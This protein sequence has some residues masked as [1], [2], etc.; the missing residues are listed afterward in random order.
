MKERRLSAHGM[1]RGRTRSDWFI[2][3]SC[4]ILIAICLTLVARGQ[5][6]LADDQKL[7]G[8]Q[9]NARGDDPR[10]RPDSFWYESVRNAPVHP[11][12]DKLVAEFLEQKKAGKK[13]I[14]GINTM[15]YSSPVYVAGENTP[16]IKVGVDRCLPFP[17]E[18]YK[19]IA[20][21][22]GAVPIPKGATPAD[23]DDSEMTVYQPSTDTLWEFWQMR[24][25]AS[26]PWQACWGGRLTGVSQSIGIFP[27]PFGASATGLPFVGG[28]LT[29]EELRDPG[30]KGAI[31]HA[32]GIALV[33]ATD[34]NADSP[35]SWPATRTDGRGCGSPT[36]IPEGARFRLRASA[37]TDTIKHPIGKMIAEAA[38][39]YGFVVWDLAGTTSL[40]ARNPRSYPNFNGKDLYDELWGPGGQYT[41][42]DGFPWDQIEFLP[43]DWGKR[44]SA[45]AVVN[46]EN[47]KSRQVDEVMNRWF[48]PRGPGAAVM[49]V[50]NHQVVHKKGYGLASL[51]GERKR[52]TGETLFQ[53]A[54]LSKQFTAMG[55]AM[56]VEDR[57]L[58]LDASVGDLLGLNLAKAVKIHHLLY[59]TA[60]FQEYDDLLLQLG[61]IS[62][63]EY[64]YSKSPKSGLEP[65][66]VDVL[67]VLRSQKLA[68]FPPGNEFHY[69]NTGYILLAAVI[70]KVSGKK[71]SA[72]LKERI[73]DQL[74]MTRTF[75]ND[76]DHPVPA[77]AAH[78]YDFD[79]VGTGSDMDYTPLHKIYG[80]IGIYSNLDDLYKWDQAL[81]P[82][83][84]RTKN[85]RPLVSDAMLETIFRSGTLRDGTTKTDYGFGWFIQ[86]NSVWHNGMWAGY[87]SIIVRY[88][89]D[90]YTVVVLSNLA[91][92]DSSSIFRKVDETY[93]PPIESKIPR[94]IRPRESDESRNLRSRAA[95]PR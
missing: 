67:A 85:N 64:Q 59:H 13:D 70:E 19:Q 11:A 3:K 95:R 53:L 78:S 84:Q 1:N 28:Q 21:Q 48:S 9:V 10:F 38:K 76:R 18:T 60:G 92:T 14:V 20:E 16:T 32:I 57:K 93:Y 83:A 56:L 94:V 82:A 37:N 47:K 40:R 54:S 79:G 90:S 4:I 63:W 75:V 77:D 88:P 69:S 65:S 41:V 86:E 24:Q 44:P 46:D 2:A 61:F 7:E 66:L 55:I 52:I 5:F 27:N 33:R 30:T 81:Y 80:H 6:T 12:S 26:G 43:F 73:F 58:A 89:R 74:E 72:F 51:T 17:D 23:G 35:F 15:C 50:K 42:L 34:Q 68:Y 8:G 87:R 31:R 45:S 29:F 71:Y 36:C 62:G 25:D 39:E 49:V 91:T 22:F